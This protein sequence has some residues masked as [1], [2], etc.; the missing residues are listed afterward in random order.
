MPQGNIF[1]SKRTGQQPD[2][3]PTPPSAATQPQPLSPR[4]W[5]VLAR[6]GLA[7]A[8]SQLFMDNFVDYDVLCS[9]ARQD[10]PMIGVQETH[11]DALESALE[12]VG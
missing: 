7:D 12:E 2:P 6:A 5:S 4:T 8:Y 9:M 3:A 1:K 10:W 11:I